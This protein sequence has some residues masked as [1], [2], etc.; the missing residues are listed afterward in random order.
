MVSHALT[1]IA[2]EVQ[3]HFETVYNAVSSPT[4]VALGN[5]AEGVSSSG[6][7]P[8]VARDR[9]VITVVNIREERALKN[10]P[11][12]VRTPA[13]VRIEYENQ[14]YYLNLT[15]L[16]TATH[17]DYSDGLL[18][19]SRAL[20]FLQSS[21]VFTHESVDPTSL[22]K[23]APSQQLDRLSEF[24]L[25]FDLYSPTMEEVNHMWG[26]LGGKQYPFAVFVIRMLELK[27]RQVIAQGR[28]IEEVV[29]Q[30]GH[31]NTDGL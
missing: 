27:H 11:N 14:P 30:Y 2:N 6:Q 16:L 10:L 22:T 4:V 19:L 3:R 31:V 17:A 12:A 29:R 28:I 9:L 13:P 26:T 18:V 5:I 24:K 21:N 25:I 15:V 20:R 1:I 8:A 7:G 23:N